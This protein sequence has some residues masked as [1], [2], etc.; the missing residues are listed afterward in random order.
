M[1]EEE[2]EEEAAAAAA[3]AEPWAEAGPAANGKLFYTD[4]YRHTEGNKEKHTNAR[5]NGVAR[6]PPKNYGYT[7]V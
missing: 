4:I 5:L 7:S 6:I 1:T 2:E 3:E